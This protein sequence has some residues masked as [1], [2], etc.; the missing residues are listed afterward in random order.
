MTDALSRLRRGKGVWGGCGVALGLPQSA[1]GG[2][3][4]ESRYLDMELLKEHKNMRLSSAARGSQT[5][6]RLKPICR[7]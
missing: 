1:L 2:W 5:N 3:L 4:E 7:T 6:R